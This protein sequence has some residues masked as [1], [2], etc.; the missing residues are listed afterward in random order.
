MRLLTIQ[1]SLRVREDQSQSDDSGSD[2]VKQPAKPKFEFILE[3]SPKITNFQAE[4]QKPGYLSIVQK[5]IS[6]ELQFYVY[7]G[8]GKHSV[9]YKQP[10]A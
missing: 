4:K 9:V 5:M 2:S 10:L 8:V 3:V 1:V 6:D 7:T